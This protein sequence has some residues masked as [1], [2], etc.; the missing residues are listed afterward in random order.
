MIVEDILQEQFGFTVGSDIAKSVL[1]TDHAIVY[2]PELYEVKGRSFYLTD[3]ELAYGLV[4]VESVERLDNPSASRPIFGYKIEILEA[5]EEP[6]PVTYR[7]YTGGAVNQLNFTVENFKQFDLPSQKDKQLLDLH[8]I[9]HAWYSTERSGRDIKGWTQEEIIALHKRIIGEFKK[10]GFNHNYS[11]ALDKAS[12]ITNEGNITSSKTPGIPS[13]GVAFYKSKKKIVPLLSYSPP[14]ATQ[15][16]YELSELSDYIDSKQSRVAVEKIFDGIRATL[17]R[18]G[19]AVKLYS[20]S[21]I[22]VTSAFPTLVKQALEIPIEKFILDGKLVE[23]SNTTPLGASPIIERITLINSGNK[24]DDSGV[25]FHI[26]DTPY[27]GKNISDSPWFERRKVLNQLVVDSANIQKVKPFIVD[28]RKDFESAVR[29]VSN[30]IGS[31]GAM[32]KVYDAPY[33]AEETDTQVA[34]LDKG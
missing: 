4:R 33:S 15:V 20:D 11:D 14:K 19:D 22:D 23:Y 13:N 6:K 30:L 25:I 3:G 31:E 32:V 28:T 10:R 16:F 18:D 21:S 12:I 7:L 29:L 27:I 1:Q 26:S 5:Y 34:L 2:Q 8:R 17:H 24:I 9:V